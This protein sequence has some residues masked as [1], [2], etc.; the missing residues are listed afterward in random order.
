[1]GKNMTSQ[2][3]NIQYI[4]LSKRKQREYFNFLFDLFFLARQISI[5]EP[6]AI[7]TSEE[8]DEVDEEAEEEGELPGSLPHTLESYRHQEAPVVLPTDGLVVGDGIVLQPQGAAWALNAS[9][10]GTL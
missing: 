9:S 6:R 10:Q 3:K 1:M 2:K 7:V 4:T 5:L 8:Q